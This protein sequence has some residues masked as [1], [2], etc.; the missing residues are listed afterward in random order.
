MQLLNF[1]NSCVSRADADDFSAPKLFFISLLTNRITKVYNRITFQTD[2]SVP[3]EKGRRR[4][5]PE[6]PSDAEMDELIE[7]Y[8]SPF[9]VPAT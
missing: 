9:W 3:F 7:M 4:D 2:I 6:V 8:E 5:E 1:C